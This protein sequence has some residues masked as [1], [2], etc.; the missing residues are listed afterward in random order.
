MAF[1]AS[2]ALH[3]SGD[4]TWHLS[5]YRASKAVELLASGDKN[6]EDELESDDDD[7]DDDDEEEDKDEAARE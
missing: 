5:V 7:D 1:I 6:G 3:R 2:P 4:E